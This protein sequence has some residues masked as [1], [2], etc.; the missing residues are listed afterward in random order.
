MFWVVVNRPGLEPS[1]AGI[2][3]DNVGNRNLREQSF[4]IG[5]FTDIQGQ[6]AAADGLRHRS[7]DGLILVGS[8]DGRAFS[9]ER[10]NDRATDTTSGAGDG[11]DLPA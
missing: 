2:V 7:P 8:N 10:F 5:L 4:P 11:A 3:H 6:E 1:H 9:D